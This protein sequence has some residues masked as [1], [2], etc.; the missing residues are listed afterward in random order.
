MPNVLAIFAGGRQELGGC[1]I[2][3]T[4]LPFHYLE[5]D[6]P[7]WKTSWLFVEDMREY[8]NKDPQFFNKLAMSYDLFVYPRAYFTD[9]EQLDR[10]E[11]LIDKLHQV[12]KK[13]IY[14]VD[15]DMTNEHRVVVEGDV[16]GTAAR[17]D[18]ITVSTSYLGNLMT[19][20]TGKKSYVLPNMIGPDIW[21]AESKGQFLLGDK[22]ILGL[23]GSGTHRE[24]WFVLKDVLPQILQDSNVHLILM[25]YHPDY[26]EG[27]PNTTYLPGLP[28][29]KYSQI[30]QKCDIILAPLN[31][32]PFNLSKSPIK[33]LEGMAARRIL[34][35][36][37]AGAAC[38]AT[39]HPV[40]QSSIQ[41]GKT[42]LLVNHTADAWLEGLD[43][44]IYDTNLRHSIQFKGHK[45]VGRHHDISTKSQ[46]WANAYRAIL[47]LKG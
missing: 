16:I 37:Y 34:Q 15:D 41:N 26:L 39:D 32:D 29:G 24:D 27:L 42:G 5:K 9:E 38:I 43:R 40:Y 3:R 2:Y 23:T 12:D 7:E 31:N 20:R 45:W 1:E 44:L 36:D 21:Y 18:A 10:F 35:N 28:Y 22:L 19:E 25:G 47:N 14:E 8:R 33:V 13:L 6:H 4:T 11:E 46:L 30:I 17:C